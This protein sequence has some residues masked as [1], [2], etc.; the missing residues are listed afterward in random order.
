MGYATREQMKKTAEALSQ[1]NDSN[2]NLA[3]QRSSATVTPGVWELDSRAVFPPIS[4][5][6]RSPVE[7]DANQTFTA[8]SSSS[9]THRSSSNA[10]LNQSSHTSNRS[11]S[12][13]SVVDSLYTDPRDQASRRTDS[14]VSPPL[15]YAS[16]R[17]PILPGDTESEKAVAPTHEFADS[18]PAETPSLA[19]NNSTRH[20]EGYVAYRLGPGVVR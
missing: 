18:S 8:P 16:G 3:Y 4:Q 20:S 12:I 7:L 10:R 17:Q 19:Y 14:V 5:P 11:L 13:V 6:P 9:Q 15:P 2:V 1:V